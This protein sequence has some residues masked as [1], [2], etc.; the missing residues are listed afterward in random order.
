MTSGIEVRRPCGQLQ[1]DKADPSKGSIYSPCR[2]LDFELEMVSAAG[3]AP[4][5]PTPESD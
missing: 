5:I 2:V 4:L 1:A 3:C